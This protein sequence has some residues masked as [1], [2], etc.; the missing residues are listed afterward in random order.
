MIAVYTRLISPGA[1][2]RILAVEPLVPCFGRFALGRFF[3]VLGKKCTYPLWVLLCISLLSLCC[4]QVIICCLTT[5]HE[6][7]PQH[8]VCTEMHNTK[9]PGPPAVSGDGIPCQKGAFQKS[10]NDSTCMHCACGSTLRFLNA[11]PPK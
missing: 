9:T 3:L 11:T 5:Y 1:T 2:R 7:E 10:Q 8:K 6:L 4:F